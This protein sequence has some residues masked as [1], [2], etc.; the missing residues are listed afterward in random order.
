M[1]TRKNVI[2]NE[3]L[4]NLLIPLKSGNFIN[5]SL[6]IILLEKFNDVNLRNRLLEDI[7][8]CCLQQGSY[9][10]AA[11]KYTQAGNK[12][13]VLIIK[14]KKNLCEINNFNYKFIGSF[15]KYRYRYIFKRL[16]FLTIL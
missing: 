3:E 16:N 15:I 14:K 11:K 4:E 7:A 2:I 8:R 10:L 13:E 12:L 9:H 6:I 1:C 5:S